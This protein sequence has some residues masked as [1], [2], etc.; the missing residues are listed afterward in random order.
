MIGYLVNEI[1]QSACYEP[2]L[3]NDSHCVGQM[4][5]LDR[6][7]GSFAHSY[8]ISDY[9]PLN[10]GDYWIYQN[11]YNSTENLKVSIQ[12]T[13]TIHDVQT[14]IQ[15]TDYYD[16]GYVES[17]KYYNIDESGLKLHGVYVPG[18]GTFIYDT[19]L[20]L[21]PKNFD[22]GSKISSSTTYDVLG[23]EVT[24]STETEIQNLESVA[25]TNT[26]I[27]NCVKT[28]IS[29]KEKCPL[30][31]LD[32]AYTWTLWLA[33]NGGMVKYIFEILGEAEHEILDYAIV[34]G[35]EFPSIHAVGIRIPI[36]PT[37]VEIKNISLTPVCPTT[38]DPVAQPLAAGS[39]TIGENQLT[40]S[41]NY[42][43]YEAPADIYVGIDIPTFGLCTFD[44]NDNLTGLITPWR[45]DTDDP[46]SEKILD[47]SIYSPFTSELW[48]PQGTYTFYSAVLPAGGNWSKYDITWFS[49]NIPQPENE[50]LNVSG[51]WDVTETVISCTDPEWNVPGDIIWRPD[52]T[53]EQNGMDLIIANL[54]ES[55]A[56]K[57]QVTMKKEN[58]I[59]NIES[60]FTSEDPCLDSHG[61]PDLIYRHTV[62]L[63]FNDDGTILTGTIEYK[64]EESNGFKFTLVTDFKAVK[65]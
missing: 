44:K 51:T 23:Y 17:E 45:T 11:Y 8:C 33:Q 64:I 60:K 18:A 49:V 38:D 21:F 24:I 35:V 13:K 32:M 29:F 56:D 25:T 40:I 48:I 62:D 15:Q 37:V 3:K 30:L 2:N 65:I 61:N 57:I 46:L 39:V 52:I 12:G 55:Y 16:D 14:H 4:Q 47:I 9:F 20:C 58:G 63:N 36:E 54:G 28:K 1:E 10:Q 42:P 43:K 6:R 27:D 59:Y 53:I 31:G 41:V 7:L 26:T 34:N 5:D 22:L 50:I 19:F